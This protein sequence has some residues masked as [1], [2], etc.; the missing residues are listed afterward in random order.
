MTAY[1]FLQIVLLKLLCPRAL[2]EV[3]VLDSGFTMTYPPYNYHPNPNKNDFEN[4]INLTCLN[5]CIKCRDSCSILFKRPSSGFYTPGWSTEQ[6]VFSIL[7]GAYEI[8]ASSSGFEGNC[9]FPRNRGDSWR[10]MQGLRLLYC[11]LPPQ[12]A[13][14]VPRIQCK[15]LP[16]APCQKAG[17]LRQ[18]PLL[19]NNLSGF[20]YIL[21]G[22][23]A[24]IVSAGCSSGTSGRNTQV[25][26]PKFFTEEF[27]IPWESFLLFSLN[28]F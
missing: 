12:C 6:S 23:T 14:A 7:K 27:F 2:P 3:T 1:S 26:I 10:K 8:L 18:L 19:R 5:K 15:G 28:I 13:W 21:T 17:W 24:G 22:N 25:N 11:L 20:C 16:S 9:G 4:K